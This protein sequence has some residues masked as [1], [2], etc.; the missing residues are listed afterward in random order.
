MEKMIEALLKYIKGVMGYYKAKVKEDVTVEG[1]VT[2]S[3][4]EVEA[5]SFL[6]T[7]VNAGIFLACMLS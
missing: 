1:E 5:F 3:I 7:A 4:K 2:T 6:S